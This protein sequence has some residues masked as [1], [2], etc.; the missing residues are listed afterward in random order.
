MEAMTYPSVTRVLGCYT[1]FSGVSDG[2]LERA[3]SRGV[4]VHAA[5]AEIARGNWVPPLDGDADLFVRSYEDW[6]DAYVT[7]VLSVEEEF[8]CEEWGY[9]GHW[10]QVVRI[11]YDLDPTIVDLKTP[12]IESPTWCGQLAAYWN[13]A[14]KKY[15]PGRMGALQLRQG[16][17][18]RLIEYQYKERDFAAFVAALN[19]YRY[20]KKGG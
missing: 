14:Q 6:F 3:S 4:L 19:A 8:V 12:A 5:C 17:P 18:A 10:D 1:D 11:K 7:E 9:M 2:V 15:K 16:K 13:G 20:F